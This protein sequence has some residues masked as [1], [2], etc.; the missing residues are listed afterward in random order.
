[1]STIRPAV[2]G[3]GVGDQGSVRPRSSAHCSFNYCAAA[4]GYFTQRVEGKGCGFPGPKGVIQ[5]T[6]S[7]K[8]EE[9]VQKD[10]HFAKDDNRSARSSNLGRWKCCPLW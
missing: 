3:S 7:Q 10:V 8:A 5:G 2:Q 1:M 4:E 9:V 6:R